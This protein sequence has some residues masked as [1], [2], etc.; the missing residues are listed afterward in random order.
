MLSVLA[1]PSLAAAGNNGVR[2]YYSFGTSLSVG[3]QPDAAGK[4]QLTNDGYADQLFDMIEPR[5]R[6]IRL[7]KMGCSGETTTT[8]ITG[9]ICTYP[10]G[11]QLAQAVK[12]LHAHKD[13]VALVTIDIGVNDLLNCINKDSAVVDNS[14]VSNASILLKD[15]LGIILTAL[16]QAAHPDTPIVG[17]TYYNPFVAFSVFPPG[18]DFANLA[19]VSQGVV[20]SFNVLLESIYQGIFVDS[21]VGPEIPVADVAGIYAFTTVNPLV[22]PNICDLTYMCVLQPV[23][24]NI[25]ANPLGYGFIA[26][27]FLEILD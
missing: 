5:Y 19:N 8:M 14:C 7:V 15:N 26:D 3:I 12:E 25:H 24:P 13:K 16:R 1:L 6:K 18:S 4:N 20:N 2:Y 10:K 21:Y 23:G 22:Y 9:G 11:S 17:M 27:A